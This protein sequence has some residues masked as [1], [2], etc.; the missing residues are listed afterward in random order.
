[1]LSDLLGYAAL[2]LFVCLGGGATYSLGFGFHIRDKKSKLKTLVISA[3]SIALSFIPSFIAI[4]GGNFGFTV[5]LL[6][7]VAVV[8]FVPVFVWG[9]IRGATKRPQTF[10]DPSNQIDVFANF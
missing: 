5:E 7:I 8:Y 2:I 4:L 3:L 9:F 10:R 1:M 6:L